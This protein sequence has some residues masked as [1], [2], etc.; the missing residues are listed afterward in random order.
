VRS[1]SLPIDTNMDC[2]KHSAADLA[3]LQKICDASL[4]QEKRSA[5]VQS[6]QNYAFLDAEHQVVF[7]SIRFLLSRGPV[8]PARLAVHLNNRGFPDVSMEKY[9][10]ATMA[11][12][13]PEED[14]TKTAS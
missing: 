6:L 8:S 5:L 9:F 13:H 10:P 2:T 7:E 14:T 3:I 11:N 12:P 1:S 4:S